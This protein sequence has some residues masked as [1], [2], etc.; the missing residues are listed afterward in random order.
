MLYGCA[1]PTTPTGGPPDREGP[2]I[3]RTEPETGTTNFTGRSIT[4]Y[5]SEFVNRSSLAQAIV[6]EPD[7]GL[8][9]DL[10][11][12]RKSVT[13][14]LD[15]DLPE[16]TT[17][18]LTIGTD[19]TDMNGNKLAQPK[20]VAVSS[21]PEIDKGEMTGKVI[22][23]QTGEPFETGRILLYR[24]PVDLSETANY[25]ATADTGG[26]VQFSYLRQGEYKA[27]WVDDRNRNKIWEPDRERAQPFSREFFT[28]EKA[29]SD[30]MGAVYVTSVDT[31]RPVLQGVG[32]FSSRRMRFRFSENIQLSDS[33]R[34]AITDT[35]GN[36][37]TDASPLYI[38]PEEPFVLFA[39]SDD[40]L[41]PDQS[42][43]VKIQALFDLNDNPL[44]DNTIAFTGSAQSDTTQQR[45]VRIPN[46]SGLFPDEPLD[47]VYAAPITDTEI[48]DSLK[49]VEGDKLVEDWPNLDTSLN[50]LLVRPQEEWQE[51][52][53]YEFR[54]W[55]PIR[56]GYRRI[57][58]PIWS[59]SQLG[60]ID[61]TLADTTK[62]GNFR[63]L[64]KG[65]S[66]EITRETVFEEQLLVDNLPPQNYT[67]IV[68]DD[69]NSNGEWD[70]GRVEPY[71]PPEPYFI[72]RR[73]P[74][75]R[76]FT[77]DLSIIFESWSQSADNSE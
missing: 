50:R 4:L 53:E 61:I 2:E 63:L 22:N 34:I 20:K 12:G 28:L 66:E 43:N 64:L 9:Y 39:Q 74:V 69:R 58:P 36:H 14:E 45:I 3:V 18:I 77:S 65:E 11:W 41:D 73:V 8:G 24:T 57:N 17:L 5:F 48:T 52:I 47:V 40:A 75:K 1:T 38:S 68:Y 13:V 44:V 23:A 6:I 25:I 29:G 54:L 76:G 10:N 26:S 70:Y 56:E 35:T 60:E 51:G 67:V 27:F 7:I 42:Y 72:Q 15:G 32:L 46:Q 55:N 31:T 71:E 62:K 16:L 33:T 59:G 37:Q 30:S 49:V 19:L 21:G